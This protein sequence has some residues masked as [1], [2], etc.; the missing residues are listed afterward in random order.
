MKIVVLEAYS[1]VSLGA[2]DL[3]I[4]RG[5]SPR[6]P[7][8]RELP[9]HLFIKNLTKIDEYLL[10]VEFYNSIAQPCQGALVC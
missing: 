6:L 5:H 10:E 2:L 7:N 3:A 1:S 8:G 4:A 9:G